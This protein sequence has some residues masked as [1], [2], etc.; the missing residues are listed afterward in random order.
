MKMRCDRRTSYLLRPLTLA[1]STAALLLLALPARGQFSSSGNVY[2]FPGNLTIPNGPGNA[3]L[4]TDSMFVGNDGLGSFSALGGSSLRVGSLLIGAS[5]SGGGKGNGTVL[6]DGPISSIFLV[7]GFNRLNLGH[8]DIGK[9]TLS[10]GGT[11]NGRTETAVCGSCATYIGNTPGSSGTLIITGAGSNAG[12][13][14]NFGIGGTFVD[15]ANSFGVPGG[16]SQGIVKIL[17][18]GSLT[19]DIGRM[20]QAPGGVGF[21]GTE[22]SF[23]DVLVSGSGSTWKI[24]G[25][26][27]DNSQASLNT[28]AHPNAWATI[29][30]SNGGKIVIEGKAGQ[31]NTTNLTSGGGRTD[32]TITG[33]GSQLLYTGDSGILQMGRISSTVIDSGTANVRILNGGSI[34]GYNYMAVGRNGTTATMTID[35]VG[36][37]LMMN[38]PSVTVPGEDP[39]PPSIDIGRNGGTGIVNVA[40]GGSLIVTSPDATL[41]SPAIN[42]GRDPNGTGTLN[43]SGAGSTVVVSSLPSVHPG[44]AAEYQNALVRVGRRGSGTLNITN[45]GKLLID[46]QADSTVANPRGTSLFIGGQS[47]TDSGG[48][49]TALVSG[50][51]SEIRLIGSDTYVGIAHAPGSNGHLTLA[52]QASLSSTVVI[53]GRNAGGVGTL[54]INNA[55][56][57]LSGQHTGGSQP[58]AGLV[59]GFSNG[60]GVGNFSNGSVV[61]LT[62]LGSSGAGINLGGSTTGPG[63]TGIVNLSGG[64]SITINAAMGKAAATIGADGTGVMSISGASSLNVG[65]GRIV[66]GRNATGIGTLV[67]SGNSTINAGWVGIGRNLTGGVDVNG[68]VGTMLLNSGATLTADTV[69]IGS[70][71]FL[72]GTAGS[73]VA[74]QIV[75]YGT[76]SP[77]SSPGVF[78]ITGD[79]TA[80]AGSRLVLDVESDG[81][82]GFL[83]DLVIF[84]AGSVIDLAA[85]AIEFRFL[86]ATDPNG[87][88]ASG[89]FN[90]DTFLTLSG[91][92]PLSQSSYAGAQFVA[93]AESYTISNFSYSPAGGAVF[94]A[95]PVPEPSTWAMLFAGI[96]VIG[97]VAVRRRDRRSN[98][99]A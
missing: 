77:G 38:G 57:N 63:G 20:G 6:I 73:I 75:N 61:T 29:N 47:G 7:G 41:F 74:N 16:T 24:T 13:L 51:G 5:G 31:Y 76:F 15:T 52:N 27:I 12:F 93:S 32:M 86:G 28:A 2:T 56:M 18:G 17:D 1:L 85:G 9:L 14:G 69:V 50:P 35:G 98:P 39:F 81:A 68:G 64:S 78:T 3:D 4:G 48:R 88:Q 34:S 54:D 10:G 62:N 94:A 91:G 8:Q 84:S 66:V 49:G 70:K 90:I 71:G 26:T 25:G 89:N 60:S 40:N 43:I 80:A 42:L 92:G 37:S 95:A 99:G 30:I 21:L 22:R 97:T 83:T 46:G 45:G 65:D 59:F 33:P 96:T 55:T 58:G 72:G 67:A 19:T 23:S 82:G 11:L 79:Y 53:V 36:S 44:G 87:F